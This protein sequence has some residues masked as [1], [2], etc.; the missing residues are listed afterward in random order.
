VVVRCF[1]PEGEKPAA[2]WPVFLYYHGGGW[3]LG[4]I[5]TENTVCTNICKRSNCVVVSVDYRLAPENPYPAA[6]HDSWEAVL[7]VEQEGKDILELDLSKLATG[8]SS[9]GGNL[10]SVMTQ[11]AIARGSPKF[12][13]QILLVPVTDNTA[14]PSNNETYKENE[15]TPA[16][17]AEKMMWYRRHYLPNEADWADPEASPLLWQGDWAKLPPAVIVVGGLDVLRSEGQQFGQKLEK[18]G[19]KAEMHVMKGMPHPFLA[20]DGVL[21]AGRQAI[22]I[23]VEGLKSAFYK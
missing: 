9:A 3:V 17:P 23:M 2:G 6:V 8:G 13:A 19:V 14:S 10:A 4:N 20:M 7:W 5:D 15:H 16:L 12:V 1:T 11:K 21:E 18:A 22:T